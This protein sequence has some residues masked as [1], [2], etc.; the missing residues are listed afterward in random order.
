[1]NGFVS[2]AAGRSD[3]KEVWLQIL[4]FNWNKSR[5]SIES[6]FFV[7]L[8]PPRLRSNNKLV[9]AEVNRGEGLVVREREGSA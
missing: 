3:W 8:R 7:V 1:M 9:R 2:R 6:N 4:I 5:F